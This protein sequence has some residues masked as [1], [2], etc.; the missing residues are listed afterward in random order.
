MNPH[1]VPQM[2]RIER[3]SN[4]NEYPQSAEQSSSSCL[5]ISISK[6]FKAGKR[7]YGEAGSSSET[8]ETEKTNV[9]C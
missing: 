1:L 3:P 9:S 5:R 4:G 7:I 8:E 6:G 2:P